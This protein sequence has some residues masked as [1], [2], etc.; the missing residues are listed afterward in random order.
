MKAYKYFLRNKYQTIFFSKIRFK[1]NKNGAGNIKLSGRSNLENWVKGPVL[2]DFRSL[3]QWRKGVTIKHRSLA[4]PHY[5]HNFPC[6][7]VLPTFDKDSLHLHRPIHHHSWWWH[8]KPF[9]S[10][11]T[12]TL[13]QKK[14]TLQPT[15]LARAIH[16]A[17]ITI[18]YIIFA[19][20]C[21]G[22]SFKRWK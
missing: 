16:D 17:S 11:D 19:I 4:F 15:S 18:F 8:E 12:Q 22:L 6:D 1:T 10:M 7:H 21:N 9:K 3:G 14:F 2:V 5:L 20:I 13:H